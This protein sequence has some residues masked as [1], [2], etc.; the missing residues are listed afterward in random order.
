MIHPK[1][2]EITARII[3]RS[4]PTR[5]EYL[6]QIDAAFQEGVHRS[7][8][9]CGNLAHGFAACNQHDK[10]ALA[11]DIIPNLGIITAYNDM[12]SAHQVF[13]D[14]PKAIKQYA[15]EFGAVAQVAGG[16]PAMCDGVTQ[17]Q[18]GMELSLY[19][20]DVIA[21]SSAIGLSHNMFDAALYLGICDKIVPGLLMSA[22][23]FG[24][25]PAVFMPGGPM[26]SG[27]S[28]EE[29]SQIRQ[30]YAEGKIGREELL[31][32]ES[33]SYHSPGTC[34]FYGTANSNQ[35]LM[36]IMGLHLPGASFV[37]P[38]TPLRDLLNKEAVKVAV[39]NVKIGKERSLAKL[40]DEKTVV[41]G[42][43][44]LLATGGSTNH[45]IHLIAIARAAG[46]LINWDDMSDLSAIV[47]LITRMYPNGAADV[48][49]FHAA[50]GMGSEHY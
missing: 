39:A 24:H 1:I 21:L 2:A 6:E 46:I 14:Y 36:E 26:P 42:I 33:D 31:K 10:S 8:L 13:E 35:M 12:L 34:T 20:R 17:G 9:N 50:G 25:L 28:N 32:G 44:G 11:A 45:T 7:T 5:Q 49:H 41:N 22:L 47:P 23:R 38:N 29:K 16:V 3:E 15:N 30:A 40:F 43:I 37:N 27:I 18:P 48:N 19:S 4:A